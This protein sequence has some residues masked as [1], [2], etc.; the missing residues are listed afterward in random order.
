MGRRLYFPPLGLSFSTTISSFSSFDKSG[1][2]ISLP[3]KSKNSESS[4]SEGRLEVVSSIF[5]S[6]SYCGQVDLR[7]VSVIFASGCSGNCSV[8][9]ELVSCCRRFDLRS[10][11]Q[12]AFPRCL[13]VASS[14]FS[15][16]RLDHRSKSV[17]IAS[18]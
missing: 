2:I 11:S 5:E 17:I 13:V 8:S 12:L 9:S 10:S 14:V 15:S 16:R 6:V 1:T 4:A 3:L 7:S 18:C